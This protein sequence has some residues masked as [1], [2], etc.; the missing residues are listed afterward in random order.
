M[1]RLAIGIWLSLAGPSTVPPACR[2]IC[3]TVKKSCECRDCPSTPACVRAMDA[4]LAC[5]ERE[6]R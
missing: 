4:C 1:M 3:A 6:R 5:V 2:A